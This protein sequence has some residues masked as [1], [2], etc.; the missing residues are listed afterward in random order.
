MPPIFCNGD[1]GINTA[2]G[3]IPVDSPT[4]FI[5]W[6]L[7]NLLTIIGGVGFLMMIYGGFLILTAGSDPQKVK[8]GQQFFSSSV[9]GLL[10]AIFSLFILRLI[11]IDVLHIPGLQ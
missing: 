11:G 7:P 1:T 2:I 8:N 10:F 5:T 4:S 9:A 3:C 6:F